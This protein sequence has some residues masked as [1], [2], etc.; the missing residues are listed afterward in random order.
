MKGHDVEANE[1]VSIEGLHQVSSFSF[2]SLMGK[3]NDICMHLYQKE[4]VDAL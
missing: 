3:R 2:I 4:R 1:S